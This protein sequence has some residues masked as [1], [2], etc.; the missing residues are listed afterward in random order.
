M[1][2]PHVTDHAVGVRPGDPFVVKHES[3]FLDSEST[4]IERTYEAYCSCGWTG[5]RH[6]GGWT[7][8]QRAYAH[9]RAEKD[10]I[11]HQTGRVRSSRG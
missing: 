7:H 6:G 5:D 9:G 8:S 4:S 2:E 11:G 10:A 3:D 1:A